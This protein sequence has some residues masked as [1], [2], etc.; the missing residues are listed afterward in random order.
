MIFTYQTSP[1]AAGDGASP[2]AAGEGAGVG[3]G[4]AEAFLRWSLTLSTIALTLPSS[5]RILVSPS[6]ELFNLSSSA[7]FWSSRSLIIG[8]I[9]TPTV[10]SNPNSTQKPPCRSFTLS[11]CSFT[12]CLTLFTLSIY[13]SGRVGGGGGV[14]D[15]TAAQQKWK[16]PTS[17]VPHV[18]SMAD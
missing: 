12:E 7:S 2:T 9:A 11:C 16:T 15:E 4:F 13:S 17:S 5:L 18:D 3:A 1:T 10:N 14:T 6:L 8:G